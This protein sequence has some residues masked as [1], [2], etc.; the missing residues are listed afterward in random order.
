MGI[1]AAPLKKTK[2]L[3][4]FDYWCARIKRGRMAL[5]AARL[6]RGPSR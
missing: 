2:Y 6:L 3:W 4:R 5:V 1:L